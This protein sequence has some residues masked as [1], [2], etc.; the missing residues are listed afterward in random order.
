MVCFFT[1]KTSVKSVTISKDGDDSDKL[2]TKQY[3]GQNNSLLIIAISLTVF[4]F[5]KIG[6][7]IM[8]KTKTVDSKDSLKGFVSKHLGFI[9]IEVFDIMIRK[10]ESGF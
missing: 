1:D 3:V 5:I 10:L 8:G 6:L 9:N 2:G 4:T 7:N